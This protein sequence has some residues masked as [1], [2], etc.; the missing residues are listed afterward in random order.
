MTNIFNKEDKLIYNSN[1]KQE[2]KV[3]TRNENDNIDQINK[4]ENNN[5][6]Y[7][8]NKIRESNYNIY[9]LMNGLYDVI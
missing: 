4:V 5:I 8:K 3:C 6:H 1:S 9:K 7:N 2:Y